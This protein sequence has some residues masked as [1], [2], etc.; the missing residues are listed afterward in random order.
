MT[1]A[2]GNEVQ[3]IPQ[4]LATV[5]TP[6]AVGQ[7]A[8]PPNGIAYHGGAIVV[9]FASGAVAKINPSNPS[10]PEVLWTHSGLGND[11]SSIAVAEGIVGCRW[12]AQQLVIEDSEEFEA[13]E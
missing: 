12:S 11:A 9:G 8:G 13:S 3:R 4:N 1:D 7:I 6:I 2:S 10:S 5:S